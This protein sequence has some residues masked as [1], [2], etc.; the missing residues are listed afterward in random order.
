VTA[1]QE[2]DQLLYA[3]SHDLR[4]PLRAIEGYAA[5]LSED[6]AGQLDEQGRRFLQNIRDSATRMA[7]MIQ[8]FAS[9][10]RH[11]RQPLAAA[12]C[13]T[14]K[15]VD[16][17]WKAVLEKQPGTKARLDIQ[18][19]PTSWG[20]ARL[21]EQVWTHLLDNAAKFS[22]KVA[23]PQI[24]VRGE[25]SP[26]GAEATFSVEDNGVGFDM[27][28]GDRLFNLFQRLHSESQFPG[29]GSGLAIVQR[30]VLRHGGRA[31]ATGEPDK[32]ACFSFA[33]PA[34]PAP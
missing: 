19:L 32:G 18:A 33:L 25:S 9:L 10:S 31:W 24:T 30:V 2:L 14:R 11:N 28:Y 3:I 21:L 6:H 29:L 8:A 26:D 22:S 17:A 13:D 27:R 15:L 1:D 7:Q 12:D 34:R 23:D 4:A 20:D 16:E 5:I